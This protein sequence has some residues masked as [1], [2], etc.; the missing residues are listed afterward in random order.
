[1]TAARTALGLGHAVKRAGMLMGSP[2]GTACQRR[3][4]FDHHGVA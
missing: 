2:E 1:M 4:I 3:S